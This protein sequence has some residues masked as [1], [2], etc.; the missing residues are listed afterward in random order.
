MLQMDS[1]PAWSEEK[2]KFV[3][4]NR[5]GQTMLSSGFLGSK[6]SRTTKANFRI[7]WTAESALE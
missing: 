4:K 3:G 2:E 7:V 1:L 6:I 5:P